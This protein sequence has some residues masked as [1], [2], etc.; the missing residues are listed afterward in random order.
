MI[1]GWFAGSPVRTFS[2]ER[3]V[4]RLLRAEHSL[5]TVYTPMPKLRSWPSREVSVP[6]FSPYPE[7]Q[8]PF[9]RTCFLAKD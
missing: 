2:E 1:A 4:G 7:P 3:E 6:H 5:P 9:V 8:S